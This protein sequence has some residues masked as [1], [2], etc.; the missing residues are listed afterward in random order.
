MVYYAAFSRHGDIAQL[1]ERFNGIEE[2]AGSTPTIST[3]QDRNWLTVP[4]FFCTKSES[5]ELGEGVGEATFPVAE[6]P[7][8][9]V[10]R[11]YGI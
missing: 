10:L 7:H 3:I 1:V 5:R 2:V 8:A 4:F 9:L 11:P 6:L